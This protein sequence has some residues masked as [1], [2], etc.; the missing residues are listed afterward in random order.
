MKKSVIIT[1]IAAVAAAVTA[2]S[3]TVKA[4]TYYDSRNMIYDPSTGLFTYDPELAQYN[5]QGLA[6]VRQQTIIRT[7]IWGNTYAETIT[8]P[9]GYNYI[10]PVV[11]AAPT[12]SIN[13]FTTPV[14]TTF[15]GTDTYTCRNDQGIELTVRTSAINSIVK[16]TSDYTSV[17]TEKIGRTDVTFYGDEMGYS[18]AVW[19]SGGRTYTAT[20][21]SQTDF[22]SM[23]SI[24]KA[25]V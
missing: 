6:P 13:G 12:F 1:A 24:V 2:L 7:A 10:V 5:D 16:D 21:S 20:T 8:V 25:L 3:A 9:N 17:T 22:F 23:E 11:T 4:D 19:T 14:H 18:Y 15:S